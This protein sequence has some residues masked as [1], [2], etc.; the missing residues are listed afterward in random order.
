MYGNV[1]IKNEECFISYEIDKNNELKI[2]DIEY[3]GV[4][5]IEFIDDK[6]I[7]NIMIEDIDN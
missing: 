5:I 7:K 1:K 6:I 3:R 4:A 2:N